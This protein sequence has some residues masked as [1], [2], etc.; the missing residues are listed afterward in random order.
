MAALEQS[1][2]TGR[3]KQFQNSFSEWGTVLYTH[4]FVLWSESLHTRSQ[5]TSWEIKNYI[6]EIM[7]SIHKYLMLCE[8]N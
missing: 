6:S 7:I 2:P 5:R 3:R 4:V 1:R 8:K